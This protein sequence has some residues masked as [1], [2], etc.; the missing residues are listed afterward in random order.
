[1]NDLI[2]ALES[3]SDKELDTL[4]KDISQTS[5]KDPDSKQKPE[6][7]NGNEQFKKQDGQCAGKKEQKPSQNELIIDEAPVE[8][9]QDTLESQKSKTML[10]AASVVEEERQESDALRQQ[11]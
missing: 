4:Q 6:L 10:R 9:L 5:P 3:S 8:T 2:D 7:G 11:L 1:M